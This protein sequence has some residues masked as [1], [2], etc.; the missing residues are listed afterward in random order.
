MLLIERHIDGWRYLLAEF[1]PFRCGGRRREGVGPIAS[2]NLS[3][4]GAG[5][6]LKEKAAIVR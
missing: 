4:S 6:T 2:Q 3:R 1:N 5:Q